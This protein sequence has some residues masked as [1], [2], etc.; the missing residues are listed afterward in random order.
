MLRKESANQLN[1]EQTYLIAQSIRAANK[2][3]IFYLVAID[4]KGKEIQN[5]VQAKK[6]L[7]LLLVQAAQIWEVLIAFRE[8]LCDKMKPFLKPD[9]WNDLNDL[10][11]ILRSTN[12]G[13]YRILKDIR[14]KHSF[15]LATDDDYIYSIINDE[16]MK[17]DLEIGL[18]ETTRT[19]DYFYSLDHRILFSYL[20]KKYNL[21]E[22]P[23][24]GK[25]NELINTTSIKLLEIINKIIE[26]QLR[27]HIYMVGEKK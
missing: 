6:Y 17:E 19:S 24:H 8:E 5:E 25:I 16:P 9:T 18:G 13:D 27:D 2:I 14:N 1:E 23:L 26:D 15:H 20:M 22:G 10:V 12:I 3:K 7:E 4:I 21:A 11:S